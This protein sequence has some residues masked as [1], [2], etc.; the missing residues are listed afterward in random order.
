VAVEVGA[1][2]QVLPLHEIAP[3]LI[4]EFQKRDVA[5]V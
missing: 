4:R 5:A 1:I 3:H 2:D